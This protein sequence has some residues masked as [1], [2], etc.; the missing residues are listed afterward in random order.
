MISELNRACSYYETETT[1][2][3][4]YTLYNKP[5]EFTLL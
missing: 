2:I 3:N 4:R 1:K 5:A